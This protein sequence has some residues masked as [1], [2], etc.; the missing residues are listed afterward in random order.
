MSRRPWL[1]ALA[2]GVVA[3]L[4]SCGGD[5]GRTPTEPLPVVLPP[6]FED[7]SD[8]SYDLI[9]ADDTSTLTGFTPMGRGLRRMHDDRVG[10]TATVNARL[11]EAQFADG[12]T[13]RF[14]VNP[15]FDSTSAHDEAERFAHVLGQMP[16]GLRRAIDTVW[17]QGGDGSWWAL[18]WQG[19]LLMHKGASDE[20]VATGN[21]EEIMLHEVSHM[22][23]EAPLD[24]T[25]AWADAQAADARF[26][27]DYARDFPDSED[28]AESFVAWVAVR[29]RSDRLSSSVLATILSAI[30]N[31]LAFFD[32]LGLDLDPIQ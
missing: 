22:G 25:A 10:D 17:V 26:I 1:G 19:T 6:P 8:I 2:A 9:N 3:L 28:M 14:Q 11:F 24:T 31:R 15:E 12:E 21:A 30:P 18:W 7:A 4:A 23:L 20:F 32:G 29:Y 13:T 27:S 16:S 5:D